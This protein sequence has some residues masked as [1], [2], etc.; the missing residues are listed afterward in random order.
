MSSKKPKDTTLRR[1]TEAI[2]A[3]NQIR[4][5]LE[6]SKETLRNDQIER[7]LIENKVTELKNQLI[8]KSEE[9]RKIDDFISAHPIE[10][11]EKEIS[12][13]VDRLDNLRNSIDEQIENN[14][15]KEESE[16]KD[17]REL[18]SSTIDE[19]N[20]IS[21]ELGGVKSVKTDEEQKLEALLEKIRLSG[22]EL[23]KVNKLREDQISKIASED[24]RI[25]ARS[26]DINEQEKRMNL[27]RD[28]LKRWAKKINVQLKI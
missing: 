22:I 4:V 6:R 15:I 3:L 20:K 12:I 8:I 13:S 18:K 7:D 23:N 5:E 14:R 27:Y 17:I 21:M 19:L 16:L 10:S 26:N 9:K 25:D 1:T 2:T 28:R 24:Y 11:I